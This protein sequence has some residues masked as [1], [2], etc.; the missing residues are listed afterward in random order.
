MNWWKIEF[1]DSF[2]ENE[3]FEVQKYFPGFPCNVC[4][5]QTS[6]ET[7]RSFFWGFCDKIQICPTEVKKIKIQ[8]RRWISNVKK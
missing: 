6:R 4:L 2:T 1:M 5:S 3:K 8:W 7:L